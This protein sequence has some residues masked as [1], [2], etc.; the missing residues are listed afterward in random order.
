[1]QQELAVKNSAYLVCATKDYILKAIQ[2]MDNISQ[3]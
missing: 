2:K 1:M 3:R